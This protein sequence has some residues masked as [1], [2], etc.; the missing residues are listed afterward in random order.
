VQGRP[1]SHRRPARQQRDDKALRILT[2]IDTGYEDGA[3]T[4]S[5][6]FGTRARY[7]LLAKDRDD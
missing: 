6:T 1:L 2:R 5:Q 4:R 7:E 3:Q